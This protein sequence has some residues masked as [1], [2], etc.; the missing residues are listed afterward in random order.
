MSY[1]PP[2]YFKVPKFLIL[3]LFLLLPSLAAYLAEITKDPK[4]QDA[5][6]LSAK[7]IKAHRPK[8]YPFGVAE[9]C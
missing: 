6:V 9:W 5:S 8:Q 7:W 4:Y 2:V 3:S 1:H